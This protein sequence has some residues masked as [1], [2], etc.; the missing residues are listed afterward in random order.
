MEKTLF[1]DAKLVSTFTL[2]RVYRI[3]IKDQTLYF[4]RIGGQG[5]VSQGLAA[6]GAG[7][8]GIIGGIIGGLLAGWW[9]SREAQKLQAQTA[10]DLLSHPKDLLSRHRHNFQL[11]PAEVDFAAI[12]E[13]SGSSHGFNF[14]RLIFRLKNNRKL[15][16]QIEEAEYV[17]VA[18][19]TLPELLGPKMKVTYRGKWKPPN[20]ASSRPAAKKSSGGRLKRDRSAEQAFPPRL[21]DRRH[22]HGQDATQGGRQG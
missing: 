15:R 13:P 7:G 6:G 16:M 22:S 11:S 8:G 18:I 2:D 5:G 19:Q 14:A 17:D 21:R 10:A 20:T 9:R 3:Y 4:I 1:L 12:E